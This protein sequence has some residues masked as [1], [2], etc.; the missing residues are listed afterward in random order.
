[1]LDVVRLIVPRM[2]QPRALVIT[3]G[4]L[5]AAWRVV[6]A[7]IA[8]PKAITICAPLAKD[9]FVRPRYTTRNAVSESAVATLADPSARLDAR[10]APGDARVVVCGDVISAVGVLVEHLLT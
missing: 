9:Q 4:A 5:R 3:T 2:D 6:L 7:T 1:M 8:E 10:V